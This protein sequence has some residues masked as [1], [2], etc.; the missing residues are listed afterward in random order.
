MAL[1][2]G[3]FQACGADTAIQSLVDQVSLDKYKDCQ[4][5]IEG[6]G[7]GKYAGSLYNQGTR[8][9][10]W[11]GANGDK[12]N[13]ETR[14]FLADK[15]QAMGLSV[16]VQG[17]YLNVIAE[18]RGT[19]HPEIVFIIDAHY[20]S[21]K[22]NVPGGD[23][24]AS[25]TA[26]ILECA[27]VLSRYSFEYTI[28][29]IG[30]NAEEIDLNGSFDYVDNVVLRN[31]E[32]IAGVLDLDQI[33]APFHVNNP[34]IPATLGVSTG[35]NAPEARAWAHT[36]MTAAKT[37]VPAL[38]IGADSPF[39]DDQS[40]HYAFAAN[41]YP[42]A[43]ELS[44]YTATD[45]ANPYYETPDDSSDGAA[46]KH[47]DFTFATNTVRAAVACIAQEAHLVGQN[48]SPIR[49][50][51]SDNDGYS[52]PIE[53]ALN[54]NP[55]SVLARPL[56]LPPATLGISL[57]LGTGQVFL[58]FSKKYRD[59]LCFT[60]TLPISKDFALA[61]AKI[62][63]SVGGEVRAF[64]LD[65]R[66]YAVSSSGGS[67]QLAVKSTGNSIAAQLA[68]FTFKA[69]GDFAKDPFLS[70][71]MS[72]RTIRN[73]AVSIPVSVIMSNEVH[74]NGIFLQYSAVKNSVGLAN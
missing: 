17:T 74:S 7:L 37:Y 13:Q 9:R 20:D 71:G 68:P 26:G 2:I 46:G 45:T 38:P 43:I 4:Q 40:D 54:S 47:Y 55:R 58:N 1:A 53:S 14:L 50:L 12:G 69:F 25:G 64:S 22:S 30:F 34:S 3:V 60:G 29:Y 73:Q 18:Q 36:F 65:R 33:L 16:G 70:L 15:F 8:G 41:G 21:E 35:S 27:R 49:P 39:F 63:V 32:I 5:K 24:N 31:K 48:N 51:D 10:Q 72:N 66:G 6:M 44:D 11:K 19:L 62:L 28:R 59:H 67:F 56:G 61:G 42:A 23:D 52:D 57:T